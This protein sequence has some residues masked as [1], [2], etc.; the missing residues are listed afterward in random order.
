MNI[1]S[2]QYHSGG[3]FLM[4]NWAYRKQYSLLFSPWMWVR[5]KLLT[6][7]SYVTTDQAWCL[8][9]LSNSFPRFKG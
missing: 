5:D 8:N 4:I 1:S 3:H 2:H 7:E 9:L 6:L